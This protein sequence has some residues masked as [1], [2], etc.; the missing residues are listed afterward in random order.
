MKLCDYFK[1]ILRLKSESSNAKFF[2][3]LFDNFIRTP[4]KNEVDTDIEFNPIE[5]YYDNDETLRSIC[6]GATNLS[7]ACASEFITYMTK[8]SAAVFSLKDAITLTT[9]KK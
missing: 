7:R 3:E 2:R 5:K 6:N 9:L 4:Y 8:T 1:M